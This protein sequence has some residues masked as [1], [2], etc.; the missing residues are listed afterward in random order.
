[1][2]VPLC[3]HAHYKPKDK[4]K[5]ENAV[6][7]VE[8]WILMRLRREA[9]TLAGLNARIKVLMAELNNQPQRLYQALVVNSLN[10]S[11]SQP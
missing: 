8:R 2:A 10:C 4:A 5:A 6:L 11:I 1:M 7:I 9:S 3:L